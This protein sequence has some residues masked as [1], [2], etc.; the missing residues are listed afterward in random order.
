MLAQGQAHSRK[1]K[2]SSHYCWVQT[3][4]NQGPLLT[5]GK[6]LGRLALGKLKGRGSDH[7]QLP[8]L[9]W[10]VF[11]M[12]HHLIPMTLKYRY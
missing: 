1:F 5:Q 10:V 12:L 3:M 11:H 4:S 2:K 6:R 9:C 8:T 7:Y